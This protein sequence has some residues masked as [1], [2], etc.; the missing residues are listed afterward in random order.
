M[1]HMVNNANTRWLAANLISGHL[2][3][4]DNHRHGTAGHS[5]GGAVL[6]VLTD[7]GR[8]VPLLTLGQGLSMG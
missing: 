6:R 8:L 7:P 2:A 1:A 5:H 4:A 3:H